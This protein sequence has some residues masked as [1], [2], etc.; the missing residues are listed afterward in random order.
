M[1]EHRGKAVRYRARAEQ[2]RNIASQLSDQWTSTA[3]Q[4][5]AAEYEE[6]AQGE[7]MKSTLR[8]EEMQTTLKAS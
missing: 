8:P 3:L 2:L 4:K 7:E 1:S 5:I 6:L